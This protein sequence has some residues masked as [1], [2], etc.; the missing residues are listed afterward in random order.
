V[1]RLLASGTN[2]CAQDDNGMTAMH[3]ASARGHIS[4]VRFLLPYVQSASTIDPKDHLGQSPLD[5]AMNNN[6]GS[7]VALLVFNSAQDMYKA[8]KAKK[9]LELSIRMGSPAAIR[10]IIGMKHDINMQDEEC[11]RTPLLWSLWRHSRVA[12]PLMLEN[13]SSG[14]G[15]GIPKMM[16]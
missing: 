13:D 10:K 1:N 12:S 9:L 14:S 15:C 4:I 11:G 7:V 3:H 8:D 16:S 6:Q 5:L 2:P